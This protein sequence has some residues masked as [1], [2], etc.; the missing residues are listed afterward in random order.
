MINSPEIILRSWQPK[1]AAALV[2]IMNNPNVVKFL[3]DTVPFPYTMQHARVY[4]G[5]INCSNHSLAKAI[6]YQGEL[7]G[8]IVINPQD[9][10]YHL[11][12]ELGFCLAEP[13]WGKGIMTEAVRRMVRLVFSQSEFRRIESKV[14][15]ENIPSQRVLEKSGFSREGVLRQAA[16]KAGELKNLLLMSILRCDLTISPAQESGDTMGNESGELS[17][18]VS[19]IY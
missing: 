12:G 5:M 15:E 8:S 17:P 14:F 16:L 9:G 6:E 18:A 4:I 11:T 3:N 2:R 13:F 10:M 7:V 19:D 1:D